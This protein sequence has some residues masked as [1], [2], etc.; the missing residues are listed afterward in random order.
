LLAAACASPGVTAG[1]TSVK[2]ELEL[3]AQAEK[4]AAQVDARARLYDDPRISPGLSRSSRRTA[5]PGL[6]AARS[7]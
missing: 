7:G 4:E 1:Q 5:L 3:W 6:K 2:P